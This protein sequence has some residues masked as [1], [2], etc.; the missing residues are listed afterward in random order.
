MQEGAHTETN[1]RHFIL[2]GA[3]QLHDLHT[4]LH[5]DHPEVR[6]LCAPPVSDECCLLMAGR[7][8]L[9]SPHFICLY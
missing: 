5:L 6:Q 8:Q 2:A 4:Q 9:L 1:M 3:S 7:G